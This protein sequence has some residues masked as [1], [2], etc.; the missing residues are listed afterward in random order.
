[1]RRSAVVLAVAAIGVGACGGG[2][3]TPHAAPTAAP[4]TTLSPAQEQALVTAAWGSFFNAKT[5]AS[6][7]LTFLEDGA[8]LTTQLNA[9]HKLT[10][11]DLTVKVEA[12]NVNGLSADVTY[13]LMSGGKSLLGHPSTGNAVKVG[14]QW[15]VSRGTFCA[16]ATLAG[17][18]CPT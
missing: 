2:G 4:T 6:Q 5:P 15:L 7:D 3:S 9:L 10:P 8:A 12:V 1:M 11:P 13:E 18:N 14:G 17:A 16:L